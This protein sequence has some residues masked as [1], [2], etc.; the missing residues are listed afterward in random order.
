MRTE[1]RDR[2][3]VEALAGG[4]LALNSIAC[5]LPGAQE[6][7]KPP[8]LTPQAF[9]HIAPDGITTIVARAS[10]CGEGMR[11]MLPMLIAEELDVEWRN[12]RVQ[13]A[14]LDEI[15]TA[16]SFPAARKYADGLGANTLVGAAGRQLLEIRFGCADLERS[17][18]P[19]APLSPARCFTP[20]QADRQV[21]GSCPP[22]GPRRCPRP[23]SVPSAQNSQG[24]SRLSAHRG[25]ASTVPAN[26]HRR[27]P[28]RHRC[29]TAGNA[30]RVH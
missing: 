15:V 7:G 17:R 12:V 6:P 1:S 13:Q 20:G 29:A 24:L 10:E 5:R 8:D 28:V 14:D 11:N 21:S 26:R 2:F 19:S 9:I 25:L 4:G 16:S 23:R 3:R 18:R 30:V 27:A 22:G